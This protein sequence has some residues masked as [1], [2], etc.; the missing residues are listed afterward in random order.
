MS[1]AAE[2]RN[3]QDAHL[4]NPMPASLGFQLRRASN[5]MIADL[6]KRLSP[7]D[8]T[9]TKASVMLLIDL[10]PG[11]TQIQ[12]SRVLAVK[13]ANMVPLINALDKS[14]LV[15][16]TRV[17]GRSQGLQLSERGKEVCARVHKI[18]QAHEKRF[19]S[20]LS[21]AVLQGIFDELFLVWEGKEG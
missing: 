20:R 5:A 8:L 4:I 2:K 1:D 6:S 10:N 17:D 13:R 19:T 3:G 11:I 18:V 16:K 21:P 15:E 7:L 14:G 12:I 9:V